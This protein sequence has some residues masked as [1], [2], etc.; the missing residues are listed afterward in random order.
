MMKVFKVDKVAC[1]KHLAAKEGVVVSYRSRTE[2][3][4]RSVAAKKRLQRYKSIPD[5]KI[6]KCEYGPPDRLENFVLSRI[7]S[8]ESL[9]LLLTPAARNQRDRLF[10][11]TAPLLSIF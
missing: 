10:V 5:K 2:E 7:R 6:F 1:L 3:A 4:R 8:S 9:A 11:L